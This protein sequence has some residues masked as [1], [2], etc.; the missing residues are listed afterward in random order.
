LAALDHRVVGAARRPQQLCGFV[1][2][3][4]QSKAATTDTVFPAAVGGQVRAWN[5]A[6]SASLS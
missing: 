2:V 5:S 3:E 6:W 4:E 1:D